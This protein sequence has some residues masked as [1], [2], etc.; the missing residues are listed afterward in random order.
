MG[1]WPVRRVSTG[2]LFRVTSMR[3]SGDFNFQISAVEYNEELYTDVVP[4]YGEIIGVP[5]T[6]PA[7]LNLS[8]TEQ[9]QN[10]TFTGSKDSALVCV[11]WMNSNT[12][13]GARVEVQN[14]G[15]AWSTLGN[16]QGQGC[17]F[18][19]TVG[20]TYTVR[21]TGF[22]WA[23]NI[24]GNPVS[25]SITV[26]AAGNAPADVTNFTGLAASGQT[27][28]LWSA[29]AGA[30][31]YEIRYTGE[32][33]GAG[34]WA[35]AEVLWDG[36][37]T[38]WT[39]NAVRSGIYFIVAV[40]SLATG[41]VESVNPATWQ[42]Q[43]TSGGGAGINPNSIKSPYN[44]CVAHERREHRR[45]RRHVAFS[46]TV[47]PGNQSA[48][49][50]ANIPNENKTITFSGPLAANTTYYA[51]FY[52]DANLDLQCPNGNSVDAGYSNAHAATA[53]NNG[54][55][56]WYYAF[57]TDASG[58]ANNPELLCKILSV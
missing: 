40:S 29:A 54:V 28:L 10:G 24:L 58:H 8:L 33:G 31:H 2:Q 3:K 44:C 42:Y 43:A 17:T 19:G 55:L 14:N 26:V 5:D 52:L 21:V 49:R 47:R 1:V 9:F 45:G 57:T 37:G 50:Q 4:N 15:G 41:S 38:T 51:Y 27:V 39:D 30:D 32:L 56:A 20:N 13:V 23:N 35:T 25:A 48:R 6:T 12:A 16:I 36:N 7:I 34:T 53:V 46:V 11:G 18:V 22:D